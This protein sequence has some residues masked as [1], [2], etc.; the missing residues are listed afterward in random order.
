M[1]IL[2]E[3]THPAH[4]HFFRNA[5]NIWQKNG[6][7]IMITARDKDLTLQ[8]LDQYGYTYN[9]LSRMRRGI[10]GLAF[11]LIERGVKLLK[12]IKNFKPDII[13]SIAGTFNVHAAKICGIPDVIFY[14]TENATVSN[15]ISYPFASAICTPAAYKHDLGKKQVRYEG[16]HELAYLHP[17]WF[18]PDKN[19]LKKLGLSENEPFSVVR[20]VG[21]T[22]GHDINYQGFSENGKFRLIQL[23]EQFGKVLIT[24]EA[25][26]PDQLKKFQ[27]KIPPIDIHHLMA[28]AQILIGESATMASESVILGR[29]AIF[30][31]P[32]GR[33]YTDEMENKFDM[34][35][36]FSD[37]NQAIQKTKELLSN[38]NILA[39]WAEKRK[40]L[41]QEKIDVTSWMVDFIEQ[42][43]KNEGI[44]H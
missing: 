24:S 11:E 14:D 43:P 31:S 5:I 9:C 13:V 39:E 30:V 33:G 42:F 35:F 16:Y 7:K 20:F 21:W 6:H 10:P 1:N 32:V 40:R 34:C 15:I 44:Y 12:V 38:P 3:I 22:S 2:V 19:I 4:V 18:K 28:F 26:L 27:V 41:L 23:L 17:N 36:T 8:L 37:E 25:P 29:P